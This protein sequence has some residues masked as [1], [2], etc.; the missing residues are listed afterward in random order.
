MDTRSILTKTML[1]ATISGI[2][3]LFQGCNIGSSHVISGDGNVITATH[4][5]DHFKTIN[6]SGMY[7]MKLTEGRESKVMLETDENIHD[8]TDIHVKNNTLY[9]SSKEKGI[10]RPTKLEMII[11]YEDLEKITIGGACRLESEGPVSVEKLKINVSG[12]AD[13]NLE[14]DVEELV[15]Q[16]EGAANIVYKGVAGKHLADLSGA[17][18]L[19]AENL[20]TGMSRIHLSGAGAAHVYV[21]GSLHATLSGLG[22]IT[23]HGEPE[24]IFT[25]RSGLG[26]IRKAD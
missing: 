21:T 7:N 12:A 19:R 8:L 22:S 3:F 1:F 25:A 9:I 14:L 17:S 18:Q 20:Q 13:I 4:Q 15:T 24:E 6:I 11:I 16:I 26:R 10:I 2:L 23:Y 5:L